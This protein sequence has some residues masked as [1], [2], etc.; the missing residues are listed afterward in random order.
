MSI[1]KKSYLFLAFLL[2]SYA[3]TCFSMISVWHVA[4][5][6]TTKAIFCQESLTKEE[7]V[8]ALGG[9]V[10]LTFNSTFEGSVAS[11]IS[12]TDLDAAKQAKKK[13]KRKRQEEDRREKEEAREKAREKARKESERSAVKAAVE[14]TKKLQIIVKEAREKEATIIKK[15]EEKRT[16]NKALTSQIISPLLEAIDFAANTIRVAQE[17][18]TISEEE[19]LLLSS[20]ENEIGKAKEELARLRSVSKQVVEEME[21][22]DKERQKKHQEL[23]ARKLVEEQERRSFERKEDQAHKA[24]LILVL[25]AKR[26]L[27]QETLKEL[28]ILIRTFQ[29]I[30]SI[31]CS[32][33]TENKK[34]LHQI[35][36]KID[37][38]LSST[39]S[40]KQNCKILQAMLE[41]LDI[42]ETFLPFLQK[43]ISQFQERQDLLEQLSCRITKI[44]Q[45]YRGV[46]VRSL[47]IYDDIP[48]RTIESYI[49]YAEEI[50]KPLSSFFSRT[51]APQVLGALQKNYGDLSFPLL[52]K[53]I[54]EELLVKIA[55]FYTEEKVA[56][57]EAL[58]SDLE[59][60]FA[61]VCYYT[62]KHQESFN[63]LSTSLRFLFNNELLEHSFT[64]PDHLQFLSPGTEDEVIIG[65]M[66]A[67]IKSEDRENKLR[68]L[69]DVNPVFFKNPIKGYWILEQA[70]R[71][72]MQEKGFDYANLVLVLPFKT[73]P[74]MP[75]L[76]RSYSDTP[77]K[78]ASPSLEDLLSS[79]ELDQ[80]IISSNI[81]AQKILEQSLGNDFPHGVIPFQVK[82]ILGK[83]GRI[84]RQV[85][86]VCGN[87]A[88]ELIQELEPQYAAKLLS[89][90]IVYFCKDWLKE[91]DVLLFLDETLG[92]S[93]IFSPL[94]VSAQKN[95][96][97]R[98]QKIEQQINALEVIDRLRQEARKHG[99]IFTTTAEL[100]SSLKFSRFPM[101]ILPQE[102]AE[103][104]ST[105]VLP[106]PLEQFGIR[107]HQ[108][109]FYHQNLCNETH[110]LRTIT[111]EQEEQEGLVLS[112]RKQLTLAQEQLTLAQ[113]LMKIILSKEKPYSEYD[114]S[115]WKNCLQKT[116]RGLPK[117]YSLQISRAIKS[118][119]YLD[120]ISVIASLATLSI[121]HAISLS[122]NQLL[123]D[124]SEEIT[125][126]AQK[127]EDNIN[128]LL[129]IER[130]SEKI[131]I[132]EEGLIE[133]AQKS[134]DFAENTLLQANVKA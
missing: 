7:L 119:Q 130:G 18:T 104:S 14:A 10:D 71:N 79:K 52:I 11:P 34:K 4:G 63:H 20:Q 94:E 90:S 55:A 21:Q 120:I 133:A 61:D 17:G 85:F 84:N 101:L 2:F 122:D 15:K 25:A 132:K 50:I 97:V 66:L 115:K 96:S 46:F 35:A 110:F 131:V 1:K 93:V 58:F 100:L 69:P 60:T 111:A 22:E 82:L 59:H 42:L 86:T 64:H 6:E 45:E 118:Q 108:L 28:E 57:F 99:K 128:F 106:R 129:Q 3:H 44:P 91:V 76:A 8:E 54:K 112:P 12:Y 81:A 68:F 30:C 92:E 43:R 16:I 72:V 19:A 48:I 73:G 49:Q 78:Y 105:I 31:T 51:R 75:S 40:P 29:N 127:K 32:S 9:D 65:A 89:R 107:K 13:I 114:F 121:V 117:E 103:D 70:I 33:L 87:N 80:M 95:V 56:K 124:L 39:G 113:E 23:E 67:T 41:E 116:A 102:A 88:Q 109:L 134:L 24:H 77:A 5:H 38:A 83:K 26:T 53:K 27:L 47:N 62:D 123:Q 36:F 98:E 74:A 125:Q 126:E 37:K